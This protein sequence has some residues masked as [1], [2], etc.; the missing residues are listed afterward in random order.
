MKFSHLLKFD[1]KDH[2]HTYRFQNKK[3][4]VTKGRSEASSV[5][6]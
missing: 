5:C 4:F 3:F 1:L 6:G 2:A